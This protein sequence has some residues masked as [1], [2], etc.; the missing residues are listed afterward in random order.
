MRLDHSGQSSEIDSPQSLG[1][2]GGRMSKTVT[3]VIHGTFADQAKW[4]RLGCEGHITFSDRLESE[5][6]RRGL[7]DT[8]WKPA[9]KAGFDYPSFSWSGLNR[10][11]DR[12][13]GARR[14]SL[15][16]NQFAQRVQATA[17]APLTVNFVAHSHGG[18]VVLETLRHLKTNVRVGRIV[19]LGTPLVTVRPAFRIAR[20]VFS[21]ILLALLF[22][23]FMIVLIQLGSLLFTGHSFEPEQVIERA[24]Q[25]MRE[26]AESGW[27]L[28]LPL[29][30]IAYGW[31]F[32]AFGNLLDVAWRIIC[33]VYQPIAWLRGKSRALV[34]GPSPGKLAKILG[35]RPILLIT[36]YNDEADLLLQ[37]GSAPARLYR[38]YVASKLSVLGRLLEF[39]FLR[40]FVLGVFLK[41]LEMFLEVFSL[42]FS[43]W[44]ALVQ[45][46][47]VA[48]L[49]RLP[50]YP[51]HLLVQER[52]DVR[53]STGK[54]PALVAD[55]TGHDGKIESS[56][57]PGISLRL[58][59]EEVTKELKRQIQLRHS[60]YYEDDAT[61][62]RVAEF[63]TGAE[64]RGTIT[65]Q[66]PG[67]TPS[68]EFWECLLIANVT[69]GAL[70]VWAIGQ[71][72]IPTAAL[73]SLVFLCGYIFPFACL[74]LGLVCYLAVGRRMPARLWRWFWILWG[75]CGLFILL[76]AVGRRLAL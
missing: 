31:F 63:L 39:A 22:V 65:T 19:L 11:R 5:L 2:K 37:L 44:K 34:Y 10:H 13:H 60:T 29:A 61:I 45:D 6:S 68:P 33:R 69:L 64:A 62:V 59:L 9:L 52:L 1:A 26:K 41:A 3:L 55:P 57:G 72:P 27:V 20:F 40:P 7:A 12:V 42:G 17:S 25:V 16:L 15:S 66:P 50:Y 56:A 58:S 14:M 46:F 67:I 53:P 73:A 36:S 43:V 4:W 30:L 47:E 75:I 48:S 38:E 32:W 21:T 54:P 18:N 23:F 70:Y 35:G 51:A 71:P 49:A 74:G 8:V 24:G 28:L 76:G